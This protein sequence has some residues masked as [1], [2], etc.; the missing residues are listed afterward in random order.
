MLSAACASSV[1]SPL[2]ATKMSTCEKKGVSLLPF[3]LLFFLLSGAVLWMKLSYDR[4]FNQLQTTM[5]A[6]IE[7]L[8]SRLDELQYSMQV[9]SDDAN[10]DEMSTL[11]FLS[12]SIVFRQFS[13]S[14][15][16]KKRSVV[17]GDEA[18]SLVSSMTRVFMTALKQLCAPDESL[19]LPGRKG[20]QGKQGQP[21]YPG[22]KGE[23]GL[24]GTKGDKGDKAPISKGEK[25]SRGATGLG[26]PGEKGD[27]GLKGLKGDKGLKGLKGD[28]G[29][30]GLKGEKGLKGLKGDKGDKGEREEK[31][32][33]PSLPAQCYSNHILGEN[34]RRVSYTRN[35]D[36]DDTASG[37]SKRSGITAGWYR[38]V[39]HSPKKMIETCPM[40]STCGSA[41]PGWLFGGHPTAV[42]QDV[43]RTVCFYKNG[44]CCR[45]QFKIRVT[46]CGSYYVYYFKDIYEEIR[47]CDAV[48][49]FEG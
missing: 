12:Q 10:L 9:P 37:C 49:C 48:Y 39:R 5:Q 3:V 4:R 43:E 14:L 38:Y 7:K 11:D 26:L 28:K 2:F 16:R 33:K 27:K 40:K 45:Y 1:P 23:P 29:L 17:S 18:E 8:K 20:D 6:E 44:A 47:L 24:K 13:E 21:G 31:P 41:S 34:W 32:T 42:G 35:E 19:C 22:F 36:H 30:K 25:G 15:A 46:N